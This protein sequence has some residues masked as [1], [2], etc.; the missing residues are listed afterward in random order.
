MAKNPQQPAVANSAGSLRF[1]QRKIST[2]STLRIYTK[3]Q[4]PS[5]DK[6]E[7]EPSQVHNLKSSDATQS[8]GV[9]TGVDKSEED[10]IHLQQVI[11]AAQQ[12]LL[13]NTETSTVYIPTP[14][15]SRIWPDASTYYKQKFQEP[16]LLIKFSFTVED[17]V[18]VGYNMDEEDEDFYASLVKKYSKTHPLSYR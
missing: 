8:R 14:N 4:L 5:L 17:A 7:L 6:N 10:E 11:N 2:K 16:H 1:R 12:A 18:G 15:A 3:D 9:D 13:S